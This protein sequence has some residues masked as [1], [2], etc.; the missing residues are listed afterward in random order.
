MSGHRPRQWLAAGLL[1]L[2][3]LGP[4]AAAGQGLTLPPQPPAVPEAE[5]AQWQAVGRVNHAGFRN[6]GMCSGTLI[7][8]DRVL[9]AAHCLLG[10]DM[11]LVPP[12]DLHFV[13]GWDRGSYAAHSRA[14][15]IRL[16][17]R[18]LRDGRLDPLHDIAILTLDTPLTVAP[19]PMALPASGSRFRT[20]GYYDL[21]PHVLSHWAD[22][23]GRVAE[24]L[25]L[26]CPVRPGNSGGPILQITETGWQV[27]GVVSRGNA[28]STRG[29]VLDRA[30]LAQ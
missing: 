12:Q 28:T 18:A 25:R 2:A 27:I 19:L 20:L 24:E 7:A 9:T 22:C 4:G 30:M 10:P 26:F 3:A 29:A 21:R 11:M 13:A 23:P 14:S 6:R 16:H 17:P 1:A 15:A 5:R 8:P